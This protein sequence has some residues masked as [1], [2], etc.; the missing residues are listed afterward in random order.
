MGPNFSFKKTATWK[1]NQRAR[2]K[3]GNPMERLLVSSRGAC[4]AKDNGRQAER[5]DI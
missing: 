4:K 5:S 2:D 1:M 3:T